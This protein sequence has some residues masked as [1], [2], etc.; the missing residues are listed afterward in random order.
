M[1]ASVRPWKAPLKGDDARALGVIARNL[2]GVLDRLGAGGKQDRLLRRRSGRQRV[3]PLA[4]G[5]VAL[6]R[7][8]LETGMGELSQ[9]LLQRSYHLWVRVAGVEHG[10]A[11]GEVD[12][13]ASFDVPEFGV[14]A[15]AGRRHSANWTRRERSR[16]PRRRCRSELLAMGPPAG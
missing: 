7:S 5:D 9:L 4:Q 2:D 6:V 11:A 8:H 14:P 13:A 15:P 1:V 10:D 16:Q 12:I 3:E